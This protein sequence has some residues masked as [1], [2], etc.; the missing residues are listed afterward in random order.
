MRLH[1]L[2]TLG[3]A[4]AGA[5]PNRWGVHSQRRGEGIGTGGSALTA[6]VGDG[7]GHALHLHTIDADGLDGLGGL[8]E[9][10]VVQADHPPG[11][12]DLG[13]CP[14]L[15]GSA[16]LPLGANW[17]RGARSGD[18]HAGY[19]GGGRGCRGD[20]LLDLHRM[21]LPRRRLDQELRGEGREEILL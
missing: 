19:S 20:R 16:Q 21:P 9:L 7:D 14:L 13:Q 6:G 8:G 11:R 12:G 4:D 10:C 17:R 15:A 1:G 18:G 5:L 2:V 3:R